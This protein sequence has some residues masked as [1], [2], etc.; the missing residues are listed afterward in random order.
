MRPGTF[1]GCLVGPHHKPT[2]RR[3]LQR[4]KPWP[5]SHF[6]DRILPGI[7]LVELR[8][9]YMFGWPLARKDRVANPAWPALLIRISFRRAFGTESGERRCYPG[10]RDAVFAFRGTFCGRHPCATFLLT[11][12]MMQSHLGARSRL[13]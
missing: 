1:A 5:A 4:R 9:M 11:L 12:G 7:F 13:S 10:M 3:E 2:T 8:V 6:G